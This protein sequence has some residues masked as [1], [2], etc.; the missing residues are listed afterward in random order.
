[1]LGKVFGG[2]EEY[3][4]LL[5]RLALAAIFI[6]QGM[7]KIFGVWGGFGL[8]KTAIYFGPPPEGKLDLPLPILMASLAGIGE[9]G[10]GF[11]VGIG[12]ITRYAAATL[13]VIMLVALFVAHGGQIFGDGMKAFTCLIMS[14]SLLITGGG[15]ASLDRLL[16]I[17]ER[18]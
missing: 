6:H 18:V 4:P 5:I 2:I 13:M 8:E 3:T 9:L 17:D 7:G 10:G 15:K 1:M 14:S 12:L 11:L 16:K